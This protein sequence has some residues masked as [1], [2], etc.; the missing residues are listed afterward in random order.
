MMNME[1]Y[2]EVLKILYANETNFFKIPMPKVSNIDLV[3]VWWCGTNDEQGQ[4][5]SIMDDL[6]TSDNTFGTQRSLG[7]LIW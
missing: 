1:G 6:N 4:A 2:K 7:Q 3:K 5:I